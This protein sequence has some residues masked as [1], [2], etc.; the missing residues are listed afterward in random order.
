MKHVTG[1]LWANHSRDNWVVITTNGFVKNNGCA[2]M[3]RGVALDCMSNF[4]D[5]P[6]LLGEHLRKNGN[7]V[8]TFEKFNLFTLPVKHVWWD[9][10]DLDLIIRSLDELVVAMNNVKA[11]N[12]Y[13][14]KPGCGNGGLDWSDVEPLMD[15]LDDRFTLVHYAK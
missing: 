9:K 11:A 14:P 12:V 15:V 8:G 7:H 1:D 10:A 13:L 2:V 3:G 4:P 5:M 6:V